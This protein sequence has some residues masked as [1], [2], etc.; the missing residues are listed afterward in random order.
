MGER[1]RDVLRRGQALAL[2]GAEA[3]GGVALVGGDEQPVEAQ[4]DLV[5]LRRGA[6]RKVKF[7]LLNDSQREILHFVPMFQK[8]GFQPCNWLL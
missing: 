1:R 6:S 3:G 7:S 4:T 8:H 5:L 2:G